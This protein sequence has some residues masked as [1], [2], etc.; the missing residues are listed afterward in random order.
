[1][2]HGRALTANLRARSYV[3]GLGLSC[4]C[5]GSDVVRL[6]RQHVRCVSQAGS[7][8][9]LNNINFGEL[10]VTTRC[11]GDFKGV[12]SLELR[13]PKVNAL[14]ANLVSEL[15]EAVSEVSND[16][17]VRAVVVS[18]GVSGVFCAGADLKERAGMS[19]GEAELCVNRLRMLMNAVAAIPAPTIAAVEG[20]AYGGGLE[21]MLACDLRVV[22][23][24]ATMGLTETSLGIIP[25]AGGTQR[26]P[27]LIGT[28]AAKEL[29]FT[30]RRVSAQQAL[31]LGMVGKVVATGRAESEALLLAGRIA[32]R[33]P[34]AVRSA[35]EAIDT[36]MEM[37]I[38]EAMTIERS[39]YA[40]VLSTRDRS[41]GLLAFKEKRA[42]IFTGQ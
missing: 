32:E 40:R 13:N 12:V 3:P 9:T 10:Q 30:A 11:E 21:L 35:K 17:T 22:G 26:L 15:E 20:A 27:R 33:G 16:T 24:D 39:M 23:E 1:M 31:E 8:T 29:I 28:E 18:S 37:D 14:G 2:N 25:G 5:A 36:G 19:Q 6:R 4:R 38:G 34:V 42:P 41:E 7:S